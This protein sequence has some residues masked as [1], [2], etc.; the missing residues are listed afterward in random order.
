[1]NICYKL[2]MACIFCGYE[3]IENKDETETIITTCKCCN[4]QIYKNKNTE[5]IYINKLP[6]GLKHRWLY[7]IFGPVYIVYALILII[8]NKKL[9]IEENL[10]HILLTGG[11]IFLA[12]MIIYDNILDI[13][14]FITRKYLIRGLIEVITNKTKVFTIKLV[15]ITKVVIIIGAFVTIIAII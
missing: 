13:Y 12:I 8:I 4:S 7:L 11:I 5:K 2:T 10:F 6:K 14:F 1:M 3:D 15:I 9:N